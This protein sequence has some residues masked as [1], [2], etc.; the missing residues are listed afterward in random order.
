M[1]GYDIFAI[2]EE[3]APKALACDWD[4]VGIMAGNPFQ[5]ISGIML[6]LDLTPAVLEECR[7]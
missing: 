7:Y 2:M 3:I 5:E 6:C 4:H 1:N